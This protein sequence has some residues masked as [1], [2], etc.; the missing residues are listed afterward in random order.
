MSCSNCK[1]TSLAFL[2]LPAQSL[3]GLAYGTD[4]NNHHISNACLR[5][6][7]RRLVALV[8]PI[9]HLYEFGIHCIRGILY[10]LANIEFN[11]SGLLSKSKS[12]MRDACRAFRC[13]VSSLFE[14]PEKIILG[15]EVS[16]FKDAYRYHLNPCD[17]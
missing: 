5:H 1:Q 3:E 14:I 12:S 13:C 11:A 4:D 17:L 9:F 2:L 7:I 6:I 10:C 15:S 16:Y 8:A